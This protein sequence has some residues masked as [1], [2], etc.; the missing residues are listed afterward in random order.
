MY[1]QQILRFESFLP[2][3]NEKWHPVD[4]EISQLPVEKD[5]IHRQ[6]TFWRERL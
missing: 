2:T 4:P 3:A 6:E 5:Q 1:G